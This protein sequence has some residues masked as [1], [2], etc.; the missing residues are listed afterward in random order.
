MEPQDALRAA[1]RLIER[2][3][4]CRADGDNHMGHA[5]DADGRPVP[6]MKGADRAD[7]NPEAVQFTIYGALAAVM[8]RGTVARLALVF[9]VLYRQA[10]AAMDQ[11][12]GGRNR[13]HPL[14]AYNEASERTQ[15]Q[16][17]AF[18]ELAAQECERIGH[19]P[20]P[21]PPV[22]APADAVKGP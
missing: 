18:L 17:V 14:L 7:I 21:L 9:D 20:F 11:V 6:L 5:R 19:G 8:R 2:G 16:V 3:G 15:E 13:V 4:W 10:I 22:Q 12:P 1:A